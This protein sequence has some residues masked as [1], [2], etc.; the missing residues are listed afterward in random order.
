MGLTKYNYNVFDTTICEYTLKNAPMSE[1]CKEINIPSDKV[2]QYSEN[3]YLYK[4]KYHITRH[5]IDGNDSKTIERIIT[6]MPVEWQNEWNKWRK[7]VN[8]A[9]KSER[10]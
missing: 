7:K 8:P 3:G 6:P 2:I 5:L 1:V 10:S 4:G 9:A